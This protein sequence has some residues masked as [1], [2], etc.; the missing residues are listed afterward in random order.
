MNDFI[1]ETVIPAVEE[2]CVD[3]GVSDALTGLLCDGILSGV[4]AV[5]GFLPQMIV[6]FTCLVILEEIGYMA[7]VAFVM[8]RI[9]RYFTLSGKSFIPLIVSTGCG[10]P[11]VMSTRTIESE[12][13]RRI[14][15]MTCT[16][17]PCGAKLPVISAI[18]GALAGSVW[19]AVFAYV[20]GIVLVI[21]SGIILRL[22]LIHI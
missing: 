21:I 16:F 11:G 22:S 18:A 14:T 13:D 20:M 10:V 4:G 8:D 6:L 9:F 19:V 5:I 1:G 15:A 2:W 3:N 12:A 17:M 7:R